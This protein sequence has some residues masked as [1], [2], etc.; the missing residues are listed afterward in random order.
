MVTES[1]LSLLIVWLTKE[2]GQ[3]TRIMMKVAVNT[4]NETDAVK[5]Y[6]SGSCLFVFLLIELVV[7]CNGV[8]SVETLVSS[9]KRSLPEKLS[10]WIEGTTW[11]VCFV[12]EKARRYSQTDTDY[13]DTGVGRLRRCHVAGAAIVMAV[14]D[15]RG[16]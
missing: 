2:K 4:P 13:S 15:F 6:E 7:C 10:L 1:L 12:H 9:S 8:E 3:Y 14:G 11:R 16:V 5:K